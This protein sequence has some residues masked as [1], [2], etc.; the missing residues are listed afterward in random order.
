MARSVGRI[1]FQRANRTSFTFRPVFRCGSS[2]AASFL[3]FQGGFLRF[4]SGG[5]ATAVFSSSQGKGLPGYIYIP[6]PSPRPESALPDE[7]AEPHACSCLCGR[8]RRPAWL[9]VPECRMKEETGMPSI[10]QRAFACQAV[11]GLDV[12]GVQFSSPPMGPRTLMA[13]SAISGNPRT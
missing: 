8:E 3:S 13:C 2:A 10:G 7:G 11:N 1:D 6:L 12:P 4:P 5:Y 9:A